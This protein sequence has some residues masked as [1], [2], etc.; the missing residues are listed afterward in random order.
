[1]SY[2]RWINSSWYTYWMSSDD[3][4]PDKQMLAIHYSVDED[5]RISYTDLKDHFDDTVKF[6]KNI[7]N[8]ATEEEIEEL[9]TYLRAFMED[10]EKEM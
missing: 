6:L 10:V 9:K 8:E 1:M 5:W 4:D 2:S 7:F 3:S